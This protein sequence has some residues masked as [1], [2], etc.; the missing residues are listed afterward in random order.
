MRRAVLWALA[1]GFTLLFGWFAV[2]NAHPD[3]VWDA[4]RSAEL[5]WI[6]PS[7]ALS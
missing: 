4:L 6:A 2:R 3:E 1:L 5:W 7:L